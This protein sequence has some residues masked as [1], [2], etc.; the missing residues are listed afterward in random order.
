MNAN[1]DELVGE[2]VLKPFKLGQ[3]VHAVDAAIRPEIEQHKSAA[4]L[5]QAKWPCHIDP[6][7]AA[8]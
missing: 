5:C 4:E 1:H 2:S 7:H 6:F 3:N 8:V